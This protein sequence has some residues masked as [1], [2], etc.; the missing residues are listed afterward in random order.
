MQLTSNLREEMGL[1]WK[2]FWFSNRECIFY[3]SR[4]TVSC[5]LNRTS[6][7]YN[8]KAKLLAHLDLHDF[9][10]PHQERPQW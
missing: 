7:C 5:L 4:Y 10:E 9:I 8:G 6:L 2:Q 3:T 1:C